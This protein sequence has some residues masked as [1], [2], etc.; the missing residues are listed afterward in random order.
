MPPG[1]H[2]AELLMC[3]MALLLACGEFSIALFDLIWDGRALALFMAVNTLMRETK[4]GQHYHDIVV[5]A[6]LRVRPGSGNPAAPC[7]Q[8]LMSGASC[9]AEESA[10]SRSEVTA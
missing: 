9:S 1:N 7:A 6:L 4:G 2:K 8:A 3:W 10:R 5:R